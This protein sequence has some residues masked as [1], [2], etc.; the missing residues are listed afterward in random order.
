MKRMAVGL[1]LVVL[2][3]GTTAATRNK[4]VTKRAAF[5]LDCPTDKIQT[6]E[7][8]RNVYGAIG[9]ERQATYFLECAIDGC[10]AIVNSPVSAR[11]E[12]AAATGEAV[13]ND[14]GRCTRA[15]L[16]RAPFDLGCAMTQ[17][18]VTDLGNNAYGASG[19]GEK[20]TY[21]V[22]QYIDV[23]EAIMDTSSVADKR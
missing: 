9:C 4:A 14:D 5:D 3:C 15:V 8:D 17:L 18:R 13:Q 16:K 19:C 1:C 20:A 6:V 21:V 12:A 23:C 2:A 22:K 7:L 11:R 10:Q